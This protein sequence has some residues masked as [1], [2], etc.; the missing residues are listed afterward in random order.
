VDI[1]SQKLD[2]IDAHREDFA[3]LP[4]HEGVGVDGSQRIFILLLDHILQVIHRLTFCDVNGE[5][6]VG[7]IENPTEN[8][9]VVI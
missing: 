5:R 7:Y 9:E 4:D 8:C 6:V 3:H 1:T 2:V